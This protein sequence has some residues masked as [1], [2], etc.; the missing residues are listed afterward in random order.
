M[1]FVNAAHVHLLL[2]HIPVAGIILALILLV[3]ARSRR[4]AEIEMAALAVLV[5]IA[6]VAIPT[7][8]T[9]EPAEEVVERL[10]GVSEDIAKWHEDVAKFALGGALLVGLAA[11]AGLR[12]WRARGA[13]SVRLSNLALGLTLVVCAIFGYTAYS[14][15]QVHHAELRSDFVVPEDDDAEE[16]AE[17]G[18]AQPYPQPEADDDSTSGGGGG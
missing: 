3:M 9:G 14:G 12:Q 7:Y 18:E 5:L 4:S 6:L 13:V 1:N 10:P 16:G 11:L 8:L 15:G 2:N 17:A